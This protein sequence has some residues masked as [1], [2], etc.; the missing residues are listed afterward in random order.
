V[1]TIVNVAPSFLRLPSR[2]GKPRRTGISHVLDNG[3]PVSAVESL[4]GVC[5]P[6]VDVWKLGWGTAYLD[7]GLVDKVTLLA[8]HG[9]L[10]CV[11]GTLLEI[12]WQQDAVAPFLDWAEQVGFPCVEVSRGVADVP[13]PDKHAL[14]AR[15]A[16]RFRVLAEVGAKDPDVVVDAE[17]WGVEAAGDLTAGASWIVTEGRES[18]TVGLF[19]AD[20]S[21][22]SNVVDAVV[23]A[24]G[25]ERTVF[26]A[27][28]KEQQAWL[29]RRFGADV[30]L[31]NVAPGDVL[32]VETLRLGLRADTFD[33][34]GGSPS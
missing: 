26:E 9:V 4:L 31:A 17:A 20:G 11:G 13:L 22:R 32:A 3:L 27:P 33:H 14:I 12:A 8:E 21:V 15:A 6:H 18:G 25:V 23:A 10:A 16:E 34:F 5:A 29:V 1:S 30:N 2:T 19:A 24:V 28:R 7:P